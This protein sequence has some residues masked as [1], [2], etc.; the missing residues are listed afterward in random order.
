[1]SLLLRVPPETPQLGQEGLAQTS[2][3]RSAQLPHTQDTK[4]CLFRPQ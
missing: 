4:G 2:G 1:M 3:L